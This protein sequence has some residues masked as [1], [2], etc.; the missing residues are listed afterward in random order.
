MQIINRGKLRILIPDLGYK[1]LSKENGKVINKV[2][3]SKNDGMHNYVEVIDEKY[4][5]VDVRIE[6]DNHANDIDTLS[7]QVDETISM[8]D[9][10][11]MALD[12]MYVNEILQTQEQLDNTTDMMDI[13]M[14]A[15]D[16]MYVNEILQT[17]EQ[18]NIANEFIDKTMSAMDSLYKLID[19]LLVNNGYEGE[20]ENPMVE[21]YVAMIQRGLKTID[22]VPARYREQVRVLLE[23]VEE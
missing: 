2:Y 13:T 5:P 15:L 16:D 17:Q 20:V 8:M 11:M 3:L 22:Q 12:D 23:A 21:L 14:M 18:L 19:V 6:L 1:L 10:T 9:I 7:V 4:V